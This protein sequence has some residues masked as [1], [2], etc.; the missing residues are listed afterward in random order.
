M[1][2]YSAGVYWA[3]VFQSRGASGWDWL[4][5]GVYCW[6]LHGENGGGCETDRQPVSRYPRQLVVQLEGADK[7][8][9]LVRAAPCRAEFAAFVIISK[10]VRRHGM[11]QLGQRVVPSFFMSA[12]LIARVDCA[13]LN[14]GQR[15]G[16]QRRLTA[17]KVVVFEFDSDWLILDV[18]NVA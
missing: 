12:D 16:G 17:V 5:L 11:I 2:P 14:L 13:S 7:G 8:A 3:K 1:E 10:R 9:A 15:S 18:D 6:D 4:S